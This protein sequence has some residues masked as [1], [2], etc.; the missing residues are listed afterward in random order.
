MSAERYD[1][2][3]LEFLVFAQRHILA[4][5]VET[6]EF[7]GVFENYMDEIERSALYV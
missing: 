4:P 2:P 3:Y 6:R 7:Y 1:F 5:C